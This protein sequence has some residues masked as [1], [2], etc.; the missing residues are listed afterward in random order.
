MKLPI[1]LSNNMWLFYD[2]L[3]IYDKLDVACW[4]VIYV[5]R[6]HLKSEGVEEGG[7]PRRRLKWRTSF[8]DGKDCCWS[9]STPPS[10][11]VSGSSLFLTTDDIALTYL[12]NI[13]SSRIRWGR[14]PVDPISRQKRNHIRRIWS[15]RKSIQRPGRDE[16]VLHFKC[17]FFF[18]GKSSL[19]PSSPPSSQLLHLKNSR[20]TA[21][22]LS[23]T[24]KKYNV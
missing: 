14:G 8:K 15:E 22:F 12:R 1:F 23:W 6:N 7:N 2:W 9:G 13:H 3:W 18:F 10:L 24:R 17:G 4:K 19:S 16:T 21:L 5:E 11:R 20:G